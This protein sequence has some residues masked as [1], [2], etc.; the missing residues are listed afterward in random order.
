MVKSIRTSG[1]TGRGSSTMNMGDQ[2]LMDPL[3]AIK[4]DLRAAKGFKSK[5][6]RGRGRVGLTFQLVG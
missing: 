6:K 4:E 5:T 2:A 1:D 3:N